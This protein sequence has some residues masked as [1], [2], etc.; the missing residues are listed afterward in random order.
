[1][2]RSTI[3]SIAFL[4]G[5]VFIPAACAQEQQ[6][7]NPQQASG[8]SAAPAQGPGASAVTDGPPDSAALEKDPR[9]AQFNP[10]DRQFVVTELGTSEAYCRNN[11]VAGGL[12]D[13]DCFAKAV[14]EYRLTHANERI[15]DTGGNPAPEAAAAAPAQNG[16][17]LET[18][19]IG[20]G[21]EVAP[22]LPLVSL[23]VSGDKLNC[24]ECI[25]DAK[26]AQWASSEA[27]KS[28][29]SP[30]VEKPLPGAQVDAIAGCVGKSFAASFR[31]KPFLGMAQSQFDSA[32]KS[33]ELRPAE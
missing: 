24:A 7:Q 1:M 14:F 18:E 2:A 3:L 16:G 19:P 12:L 13:C 10:P 28:L 33:C 20:S 27:K 21:N 32:L 8:A 4:C 30:M 22:M 23:A 17:N 31:A 5:L 15:N 29:T 6:T 11:P 9:L 26:A 25:S